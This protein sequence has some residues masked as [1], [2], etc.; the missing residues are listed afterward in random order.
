MTGSPL[1]NNLEEYWTLIEWIDPGYLGPLNEF[2]AKYVGP[3]QDGLYRDSSHKEQRLSSIMLNVLKHDISYKINR[4]DIE[5]IKDEMP[6]KTE[7]LITVP[8]TALQKE[9]YLQFVFP[10]HHSSLCISNGTIGISVILRSKTRHC[11]S[12]KLLTN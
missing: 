6:Q 9:F 12:S 10:L 8:L 1:S 3:I 7:F 4:A 5:V 2:R 11:R